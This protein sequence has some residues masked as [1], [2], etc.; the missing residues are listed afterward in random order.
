M[1][2]SPGLLQVGS[3]KAV[4]HL[5]LPVFQVADWEKDPQPGRSLGGKETFLNLAWDG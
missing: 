1:R 5:C 4:A 2:Q 3:R